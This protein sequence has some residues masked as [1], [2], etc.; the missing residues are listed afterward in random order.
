VSST[1]QGPEVSDEEMVE[2]ARD[3]LADYA[4]EQ[5]LEDFPVQTRDDGQ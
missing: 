2:H 1:P 3:F 4:I 5:G